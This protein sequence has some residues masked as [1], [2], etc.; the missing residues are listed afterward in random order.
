MGKL[1]PNP[2]TIKRNK[3]NL[4]KRWTEVISHDLHDFTESFRTDFAVS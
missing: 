3:N 1:N 2:I 4:A